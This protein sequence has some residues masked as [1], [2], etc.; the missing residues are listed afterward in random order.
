MAGILLT[1]S[2]ELQL[3][4]QARKTF[5]T[6]LLYKGNSQPVNLPSAQSLMKLLPWMK[7]HKI[8]LL[9]STYNVPLVIVSMENECTL[10]VVD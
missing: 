4:L 5:I 10:D 2:A 8:K 7:K 6:E 1:I 3:D 9:L